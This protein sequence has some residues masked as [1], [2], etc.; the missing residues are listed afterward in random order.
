MEVFVAKQPVY[1]IWEEIVAYELFYRKDMTNIFPYID[2]D[3]ATSDVIINSFLNIGIDRISQGKRC[4][5]QFTEN[6]LEKKLPTLFNPKDIIVKINNQVKPSDKVIQML[7]ELK[8]LGY[9]ISINEGFLHCNQANIIT[10]LQNIDAIEVDFLKDFSEKQKEIEEAAIRHNIQL[11]ADKI[12]TKEAF[13]EA[14]MRGYEFFQGYYFSEPVII[15]T[16]EIPTVF[17]SCYQSSQNGM[18]ENLDEEELVELLEKDLSLS[19]KLL[20]LINRNSIKNDKKICSIRRAIALIGLDG[21]KKWIHILSARKLMV[22]QNRLSSE[23]TRQTLTRAK[24]C[25]TIAKQTGTEQTSGYYMTGLMSTLEEIVSYTMEEILED[26][27]LSDKI[28]DAL[29]GKE[30]EFKAVLDLAE[31]VERAKWKEINTIC[32]KLNITD[33][34]LF[35]IYAE[36][37]NWTKQMIQAEKTASGE[38]QLLLH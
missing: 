11:L 35:R 33:R 36:S 10:I 32:K 25:E 31:A 21:V 7:K 19:I 13:E 12:E 34:E 29:V 37:L 4:G 28:H 15:S 3:Q 23:L 38:D 20:R 6:L 22:E 9:F 5:I 17:T 26:L 8:E 16:Y 18:I 14:K 2:G 30:N 24:F 1:N 27:P